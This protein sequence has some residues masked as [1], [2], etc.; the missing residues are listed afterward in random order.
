[1]LS[2]GWMGAAKAQDKTPSKWRFHSINTVGWIT[3]KTEP[4]VQLQTINGFRKDHLFLGLGV[5][6]D[7]YKYSG[8]AAFADTRYYLGKRPSG[9]F[10]YGDG[11]IHFP[12]VTDKSLFSNIRYLKGFY[13]D[14]GAGYA[15][16]CGKRSAI[17]FSAG[18]T[19]KRVTQ[20]LSYWVHPTNAPDY[21]YV[22]KYMYNLTRI[23]FKAGFRF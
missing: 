6:T 8:V 10:A 16:G 23:V 19:Y 14:L 17:E 11:G 12:T 9:F 22:D 2:A 15:V 3:G 21:E 1:M 18:W 5:G 4:V 7:H 20:R 13:S